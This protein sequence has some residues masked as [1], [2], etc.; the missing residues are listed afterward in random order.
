MKS[1]NRKNKIWI[2]DYVSGDEVRDREI[3]ELSGSLGVSELLAVLLYNRGYKTREEAISFIE[4]KESL[5]HDPYLLKDMDKAVNRIR[6]AVNNKE[7]IVIYG[8]YDVDGVTAVSTLFLYLESNGANVEYY[9]PSRTGEGYGLSVFTI[10]K[11]LKHDINLIVTVDTGITAYE[12]AEYC[13]E[14]NVDLIITDHHEC[15]DDLPAAIAVVNPHRHDCN[16]PFAEIAGVGVVFKLI[17][18]YEMKLCLENGKNVKDGIKRIFDEYADLVAIGTIADVMPLKDENRSIVAYG[19]SL[20]SKTKRIGLAELIIAS[21]SG[22]PYVKPASLLAPPVVSKKRKITTNYIGYGI[23]PRINAAGRIS[24]ASKAVELLLADNRERARELAQE[25][26]EINLERQIQENQ[27]AEKAYSIIDGEF[28][29]EKDKVIVLADNSWKQGII[30]IVSSRITEKYGLPSILV[31]FDNTQSE[32]E[33]PSDV[34]KGSGRSVKG[35]NLVAA[36]RSCDD[37]LLKYGGHELAAGLSIER[38]KLE[39]FKK[40]INAY[41]IEHLRDED[42]TVQMNADCL[43]EFE[44][45]S[46]KFAYE[47]QQLEPFGT[48][49]LTPT[50]ITCN[51][52]IQKV[53]SIG[54][55]KHT[56]LLLSKDG[57]TIPALCFGVQCINLGFVEGESIDVFYNLDIND[58]QNQQTLQLIVSDIRPSDEYKREL[59]GQIQR[60]EQI[61]SGG[62]FNQNE[63]II[64]L[65]DD[66]VVVYKLIRNQY[67]LG[68]DAISEKMLLSMVTRE[69]CNTDVNINYIKLKFVLEIMNELK[70]CRIEEPETGKYIFCIDYK[71][72]KT[73]IEKSYV[74]KK[75]KSQ[76]DE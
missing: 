14:N 46:L 67:R 55:G 62:R 17:C 9:I 16:Y 30:G 20:I 70:I 41:A 36:L 43:V 66:I 38:G 48:A 68:H 25:L 72:N 42:L 51:V 23:A 31:S 19:L 47:I 1:G 61:K 4:I 45:L 37:C 44:N 22:N 7:K 49:N 5:F 21:N 71:T 54:A 6:D 50:F 59:D 56:K 8:D 60:Y 18:A 2:C 74:L 52:K 69:C 58:F 12:E 65:R 63:D 11:L 40:A 35:M 75:L 64:P 3:R 13:R 39:D 26:C 28:D 15:R 76:C 24:S 57:I 27:I 53:I 33:Y 34:G 32:D 10:D 73:N 29:F